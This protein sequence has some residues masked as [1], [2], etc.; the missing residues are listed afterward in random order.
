M[1]KVKRKCGF[2]YREKVYIY[3]KAERSPWFTR[4]TDATNWKRNKL[5]ERDKLKAL[6]INYI[7]D[8]K[9]EEYARIFISNKSGLAK[10]TLDSY[11]S[12]LNL[13]IIPM[14]G[15]LKI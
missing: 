7:E 3:G 15:H 13:Y 10:R 12:A 1:E 9:T 8:L 14:F 4:K 2:K 5:N 11:N 6:G